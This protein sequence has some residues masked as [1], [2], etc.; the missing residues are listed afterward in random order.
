MVI[1]STFRINDKYE[2]PGHAQAIAID[3]NGGDFYYCDSAGKPNTNFEP[4]RALDFFELIAERHGVRQIL[5]NCPYV[6]KRA[7][8]AYVNCR[9]KKHHDH[10]HVDFEFHYPRKDGQTGVFITKYNCQYGNY[11]CPKYNNCDEST[12]K[13]TLKFDEC[14]SKPD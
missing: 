7:K 1:G 13:Y 10:S 14:K 12:L 11:T 6:I 4:Q 9:Y 5:F 2:D 8:K 3:L